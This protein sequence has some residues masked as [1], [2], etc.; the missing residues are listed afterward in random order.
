MSILF[1]DEE[2]V[3]IMTEQ[4]NFIRITT[5]DIRSIGRVAKGVRGIKLNEGDSVSCA[6]PIFPTSK[7]IVSVT[8]SGL[9]KKTTID[10]FSVQGKNTKGSKIH[11][12]TD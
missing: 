9:I 10:E 4:G 5:S 8:S 3:G 6:Y 12:L 1:L 2:D 11:K 7:Y